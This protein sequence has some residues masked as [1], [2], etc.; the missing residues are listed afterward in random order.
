MNWIRSA[1]RLVLGTKD[2]SL[3]PLEAGKIFLGINFY[4]YDYSLSG[5]GG[6]ITGNDYLSVL[7]KYKPLVQWEEISAEHFI[8]YTDN[9]Q[10]K[11]AVFYPS[12][13]SISTRLEAAGSL[14]TGISI[15]EI[16]QGLDY[17]FD[18]L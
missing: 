12:L 9:N 14:G 3:L 13:K 6:A 2:N 17:F 1:L 16:G 7:S 8:L 11:H 5:G 10:N 15:W 4:G 18:L